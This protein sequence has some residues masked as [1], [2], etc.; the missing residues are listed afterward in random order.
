MND[1][2]MLFYILMLIAQTVLIFPRRLR[3]GGL[4]FY[5]IG[6]AVKI[7]I[8]PTAKAQ[9]RDIGLMEKFIVFNAIFIS[10]IATIYLALFLEDFFLLKQKIFNQEL[11]PKI[12]SFINQINLLTLYLFTWALA[13]VLGLFHEYMHM[14]FGRIV[15][16]P[17]RNLYIATIL[18]FPLIFL[19]EADDT[20]A[21]HM[22]RAFMVSG[23]IIANSLA[24]LVATVL[25]LLFPENTFICVV[26][27]IVLA[28]TLINGTVV[29][30]IAA[31]GVVIS[32]E[33]AKYYGEKGIALLL[34][35]WILTIILLVL[36]PLLF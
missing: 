27:Y 28:V 19:V 14:C 34:L 33:T 36:R 8:D 5:I 30:I 17:T 4:Y 1:D 29:N 35:A 11:L 26:F 7:S 31:D 20:K 2:V 25:L 32:M 3:R 23:G 12:E 9:R 6:F 24:L 15:G 13:I 22:Q 16:I 18:G 21:S 10:L